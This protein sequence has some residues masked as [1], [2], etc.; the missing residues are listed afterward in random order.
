MVLVEDDP[1]RVVPVN[2]TLP[3]F[4]TWT[5]GV[6]LPP[7]QVPFVAWRTNWPAAYRPPR[8]KSMSRSTVSSVREPAPVELLA[9]RMALVPKPWVP[10][11]STRVSVAVP[12]LS[13][14]RASPP[15]SV[16]NVASVMIT[17]PDSRMPC[18]RVVTSESTIVAMGKATNEALPPRAA[19]TVTSS[20]MSEEM[21][22]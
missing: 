2:V 9:R 15:S 10:V 6:A 8:E 22:S 11:M 14:R 17:L 16:V 19:S 1:R 4:C 20:S 3:P 18:V 21:P 7:S 12:T 5:R 13:M